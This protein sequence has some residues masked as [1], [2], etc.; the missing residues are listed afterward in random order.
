M[1]A[2]NYANDA[3]GARKKSLV[4]LRVIGVIRGNAHTPKSEIRNP[5]S[6]YGTLPQL[7][8]LYATQA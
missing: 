2:A 5:K 1:V 8:S 7:H 6:V 3:K 4:P